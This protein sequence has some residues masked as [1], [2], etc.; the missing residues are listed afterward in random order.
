MNFSEIKSLDES[1]VI[2]TYGRNQIAVDHGKGATLWDT[3]GKEY[4]DFTSGIGVCSLGYANEAWAKAIY[5][6]AMQVGHIS[7]LFYTE[8]YARLASRLVP[9]SGMAAA[10]F[11]N[12]GSSDSKVCTFISSIVGSSRYCDAI[13]WSVSRSL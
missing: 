4:I 13:I 11:G 2:Q 7:N 8:P 12:S 1:F 9:A 6:Q 5:D 3:E 10:F